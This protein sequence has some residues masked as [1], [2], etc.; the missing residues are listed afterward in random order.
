MFYNL[1]KKLNLLYFNAKTNRIRNKANVATNPE[2]KLIIVTLLCEN[3]LNMY[4]VAISSL[5]RFVTPRK[6]VV[7][8]DN[9]S[10]KSQNILRSCIEGVKILPVN[11]CREPGLPIGG[12]WER[13][14]TILRHLDEGYV[15]QMDADTITLQRPDELLDAIDRNVSCTIISKP[16]CK[17]VTFSEIARLVSVWDSDHV[18]VDSEKA[19]AECRQAETRLYVRG[20]AAYT[21]FAQGSSG[22]NDLKSFS[23]ELEEKLGKERW[24]T[25]G[26]EQVASNY[27]IANSPDSVLLPFELYPYYDPAKKNGNENIKLFHFIGTHRFKEGKYLALALELIGSL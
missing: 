5:C 16:D 3:D 18:Q 15:M 14:A 13:L 19:L 25:W 12:C 27:I 7:V 8:S 4:L 17:K 23:Q 10:E 21:G 26:T 9:L 6:V 20:C 22:L 24:R 1:R 2:S 11:E